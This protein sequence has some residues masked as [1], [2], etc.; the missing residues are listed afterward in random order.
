ME[1]SQHP[2]DIDGVSLAENI[3]AK[4]LEKMNE[5]S[6]EDKKDDDSWW[7]TLVEEATLE[8][9]Q[10]LEDSICDHAKEM[11]AEYEPEI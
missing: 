1:N 8:S 5:L 4:F 6:D 2:M 3:K 10:E 11:L 9:L 7:E